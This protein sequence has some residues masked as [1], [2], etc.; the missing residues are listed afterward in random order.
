MIKKA[1]IC[2][3]VGRLGYT[4]ARMWVQHKEM[5]GSESSLE[6]DASRDTVDPRKKLVFVGMGINTALYPRGTPTPPKGEGLTT[7]RCRATLRGEHHAAHASMS[8]EGM[9]PCL[10]VEGATT[11]TVF[12]RPASKKCWR[13]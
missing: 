1:T 7:L 10:T 13:L 11:P 12:W 4:L 8:L 5:N 2:R 3:T 6:V 9:D